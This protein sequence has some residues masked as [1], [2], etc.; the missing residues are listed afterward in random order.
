MKKTN[1]ILLKIFLI[2]SF[3]IISASYVFEY[4][5]NRPIH[6][7]LQFL[8]LSIMLFCTVW[9]LNKT[10]NLFNNLTKNKK[11]D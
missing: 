5:I 7:L 3:W 10:V 2:W 4:L 1:F 8:S 11:N 6:L 9:A